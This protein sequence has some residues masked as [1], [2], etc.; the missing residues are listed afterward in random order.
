MTYQFTPEDAAAL[1]GKTIS[2]AV[3][4][5]LPVPTHQ[6]VFKAAFD[7]VFACVALLCLSPILLVVGVL[8]AV[9]SKGPILFGHARVGKGGVSFRCYKFRTMVPDAEARLEKALKADPKLRQE[10]EENRKLARDPRITPIGRIL[11][12][13]SLDELPQFWNVL[14]G[15]MSI[16]GPR[17]IVEAELEKYGPHASHYLSV[18]PGITGAWQTNGRSDVSYPER[19]AMDVDYVRT[20]SLWGDIKIVFKTVRVVLAQAG[21]H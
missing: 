16:V 15:D 6:T 7:R 13:T 11:R 2:P 20:M 3:P 5:V 9:T 17:P 14:R 1:R 8:V 18:R 10:W 19:V 21:A 4:L 12:K